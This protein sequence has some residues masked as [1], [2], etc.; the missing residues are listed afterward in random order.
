[1]KLETEAGGRGG[2]RKWH[3]EVLSGEGTKAEERRSVTLEIKI[4]R[5]FADPLKG[6]APGA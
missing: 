1:M 4:E 2:R 6:G 5:K 3:E